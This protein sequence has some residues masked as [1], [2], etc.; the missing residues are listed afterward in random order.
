MQANS[1]NYWVLHSLLNII[2]EFKLYYS[3]VILKL[4]LSAIRQFVGI[5]INITSM[6]PEAQL[7][8]CLDIAYCDKMTTA[9]AKVRWY[10]AQQEKGCVYALIKVLLRYVLL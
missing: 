1:I 5:T 3:L 7:S 10:N 2:V 4:M 6:P 8:M 9:I